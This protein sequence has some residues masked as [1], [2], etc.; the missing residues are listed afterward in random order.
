MGRLVH[1]ISISRSNEY[2]INAH[3]N[4]KYLYKP[5]QGMNFEKLEIHENRIQKI[6]DWIQVFEK[7]ED[8]LLKV[9]SIL[10]D[11]G[12]GI[13]ADTFEQALEHLGG[14]IG[15]NSERPEKYWKEGP[16]NL[17]CVERG[18]YILFECKNGVK[19]NRA[20]I[21]K[22][23]TGQMSNSCNWFKRKYEHSEYTPVM[24]INT[25]NVAKDASL[26]SNV[27]IMKKSKLR[28]LK[29]NVRNFFKEFL[30]L[31]SEPITSEKIAKLLVV[32]KLTVEDISSFYF[33]TVYH[34]N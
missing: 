15:F 30:H 19:E 16:D 12:F 14:I 9:D 21:Y 34:M 31:K 17:W 11:L 13:K 2:Q 20:E 7:Q 3:Q 32:H 22:K 4:N 5:N 29:I 28:L 23:E 24:I 33:S 8:L 25:R 10:D 6:L 18:K 27:L 26:D 1:P